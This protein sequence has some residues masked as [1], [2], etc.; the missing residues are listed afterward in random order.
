MENENGLSV[1][2][3]SHLFVT[4]I[5][6]EDCNMADST[7]PKFPRSPEHRGFIA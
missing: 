5:D 4:C 7:D 3:S 2:R 6:N 1:K